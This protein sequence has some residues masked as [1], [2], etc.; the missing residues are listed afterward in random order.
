MQ[1]LLTMRATTA[2]LICLLLIT[3]SFSVLFIISSCERTKE[4]RRENAER[5]LEGMLAGYRREELLASRTRPDFDPG[6]HGY[7]QT[8]AGHALDLLRTKSVTN[9]V[10]PLQA[11]LIVRAGHPRLYVYFFDAG[12]R[13]RGF[14]LETDSGYS[15]EVL[16]L[17]WTDE[18]RDLFGATI[19]RRMMIPLVVDGYGPGPDTPR[20]NVVP[21]IT[22]FIEIPSEL[23]R[24]RC[25]MRLAIEGGKETPPIDLYVHKAVLE[26]YA[27]KLGGSPPKNPRMQ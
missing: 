12:F 8:K 14:V 6:W 19:L 17:R 3:S 1:E 25:R 24:G 23:L 2:I 9:E 16:N 18:D 21:A 4:K 5:Y 10:V 20:E 22:S 26:W 7:C 11:S 27:E 15:G 13:S